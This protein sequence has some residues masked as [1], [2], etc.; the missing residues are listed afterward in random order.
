MKRPP[1]V[2]TIGKIETDEEPKLPFWSLEPEIKGAPKRAISD[3]LKKNSLSLAT[4]I[5]HKGMTERL[6][7]LSKPLGAQ[8][9]TRSRLMENF[10]F[11][12]CR[13]CRNSVDRALL[14]FARDRYIPTNRDRLTSL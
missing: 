1:S 5:A 12:R 3:R 4:R 2:Y 14:E 13:V 10:P 9:Y 11:R 7:N 6:T 8:T